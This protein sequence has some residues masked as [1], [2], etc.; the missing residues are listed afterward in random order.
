MTQ[1]KQNWFL[2]GIK[3]LVYSGLLVAAIHS[4]FY[5]PF[6]IP[7]GSMASTLLIGDYLFVSKFAYGY[8]NYSFPFSP[9][10]ING[11][12]WGSQPKLGDVVVF[13]PPHDPKTDWVKRLVGLPGDHIQVIDGYLYI[14]GQKAELISQGSTVWYD[15][16]GRKHDADLY[17]ETLPN[18]VQHKILKEKP[19][20]EGARDNTQEFTVPEGFYF[21]MGDNRDNSDDSRAIGYI[22]YKNLVG[23]ANIIFYSTEIPVLK[24][25]NFFSY[26]FFPIY[27]RYGRILDIIH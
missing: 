14:N 2:E 9:N 24:D 23:Q 20:G 25:R 3:T 7:S 11:R 10:I 6:N 19:F 1:K 12:L 16:Y 22:P 27:I 18:G 8:S 13:R 21:M 15:Q 5:K 4:L 26:L 17:I